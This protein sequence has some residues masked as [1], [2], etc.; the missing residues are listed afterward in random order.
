MRTIEIPNRHKVTILTEQEKIDIKAK[1]IEEWFKNEYV[2][3]L[4]K[5]EMCEY[6]KLPSEDTKYGLFRE[7]YDKEQE[8][9]KLTG[10]ELLPEIITL[11]IF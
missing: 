3:R 2:V 9:R 5:V 11:D 4:A 8:Y 7:A 6:F 10:K 1:E